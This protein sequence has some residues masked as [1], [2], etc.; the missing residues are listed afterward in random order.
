ME[1]GSNISTVS[2]RVAVGDEMGSLKSET[3]KYGSESQGNRIRERLRWREPVASHS[4]SVATQACDATQEYYIL[5][6]PINYLTR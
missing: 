5:K 4:F 3:V 2:L 6:E 1:A